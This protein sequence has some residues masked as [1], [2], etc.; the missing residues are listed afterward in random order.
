MLVR[1]VNRE[2]PDKQPDLGLCCLSRPFGQATSGQNFR[3]FT[4][5]MGWK[6]HKITKSHHGMQNTLFK[7]FF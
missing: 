5:S 7:T 2:D 6:Y 1:K 4:I 3:T